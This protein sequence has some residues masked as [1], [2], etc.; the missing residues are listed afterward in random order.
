MNWP[1]IPFKLFKK[2]R[3]QELLTVPPCPETQAYKR[4][5][6]GLF[7]ATTKALFSEVAQ[8][9]GRRLGPMWARK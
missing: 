1:S 8:Y 7:E 3:E 6:D 2:K 5:V 9:Q 4:R